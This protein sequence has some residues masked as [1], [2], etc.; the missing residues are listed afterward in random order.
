MIFLKGIA[1]IGQEQFIAQM[2]TKPRIR[3]NAGVVSGTL[4]F[5]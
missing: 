4:E 3:S 2:F 1:K 5:T